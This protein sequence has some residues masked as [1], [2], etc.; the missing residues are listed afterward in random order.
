MLK[1]LLLL[2]AAGSIAAPAGARTGV[3]HPSPVWHVEVREMTDDE[4]SVVRGGTTAGRRI[5]QYDIREGEV[6]RSGGSI[7]YAGIPDTPTP[8]DVIRR[9]EARAV[10][11]TGTTITIAREDHAPTI[12]VDHVALTGFTPVEVFDTH[13]VLA[14]TSRSSFESMLRSDGRPVIVGSYRVPQ[15]D[16]SRG[17]GPMRVYIVSS[18]SA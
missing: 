2:A 8:E 12:R 3:Q 1:V 4:A 11:E 15:A 18:R 7:T 10:V 5:A 13:Y 14:A 16:G 9:Y 6:L 17:V